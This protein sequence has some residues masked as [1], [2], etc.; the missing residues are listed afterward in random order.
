LLL[1]DASHSVTASMGLSVT[2]L[3]TIGSALHCLASGLSSSVVLSCR[4]SQLHAR[5]GVL[6]LGDA[7]HSVTASMGQGANHA[8]ESG[9]VLGRMVAD[10]LVL[11]QAGVEG[12]LDQDSVRV[13]VRGIGSGLHMC[14]DEG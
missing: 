14:Q 12:A 2:T 10:R 9:S 3:S 1:G 8:L 4:C 13:K 6:L 11:A 5:G 7:G